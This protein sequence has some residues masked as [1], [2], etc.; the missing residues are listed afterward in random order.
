MGTTNNHAAF[1]IGGYTEYL[2]DVVGT[3][4][5][6]QSRYRADD[7]RP[8]VVAIRSNPLR[9]DARD[10]LCRP[11]ERLRR[12]HVR[13]IAE[14]HVDQRAAAVDRAITIAPAII[15]GLTA[16]SSG[17]GA[18]SDAGGKHVRNAAGPSPSAYGL[19]DR[20]RTL[21]SAS[22]GCRRISSSSTRER[23]RPPAA[24]ISGTNERRLR[25]GKPFWHGASRRARPDSDTWW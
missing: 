22:G 16:S 12:R 15:A 19:M 21:S 25:R 4:D 5:T 3:A 1:W 24:L 13:A 17:S 11:E 18:A 10:R 8:A 6:M 9:R 7:P 20:I 23:Y 2:R 14:H